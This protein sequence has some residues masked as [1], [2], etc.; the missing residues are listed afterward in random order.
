MTDADGNLASATGTW[1]FTPDD[2]DV[3]VRGVIKD[4][5]YMQFGYWLQGTEGEDGTTYGVS[6]FAGGSPVF[7]VSNAQTLTGSASYAGPATGMFVKKT[8][9]AGGVAT[10]SSSGQFTADANLKAYFDQDTDETIAPGLVNSISGTVMNFMHGGE[11]IDGKWTVELM[12]A[13]FGGSDTTT[14]D[15]FTGATTGDGQWQGQF[16]GTVG[17]DADDTP[18]VGTPPSGVAGEFNGHFTNGHV[19]GAFGATMQEE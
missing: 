2:T 10:P 1:T 18:A 15:T 14:N 19:I 5:E 9:D 4:P 17:T 6:T 8:F 16:I 7:T 3:M 13:G 12:R 11:M